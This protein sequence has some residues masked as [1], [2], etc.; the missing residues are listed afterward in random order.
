MV[1]SLLYNSQTSKSNITTGKDLIS[2]V[3]DKPKLCS[4][5][6]D[7]FLGIQFWLVFLLYYWKCNDGTYTDWVCL[8]TDDSNYSRCLKS[9][10]EREAK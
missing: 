10:K 6:E 5:Q 1:K 2:K 7:Y 8:S 4:K 9:R 3:V